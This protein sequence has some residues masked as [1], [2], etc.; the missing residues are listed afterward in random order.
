MCVI[1]KSAMADEDKKSEKQIE[2]DFNRLIQNL[3]K[4]ASEKKEEKSNNSEDKH[5]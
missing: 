2:K 1:K 3:L 4:P 5:K